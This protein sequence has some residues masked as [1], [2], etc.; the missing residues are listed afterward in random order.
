MVVK[1][2]SQMK[3]SMDNVVQLAA[4]RKRQPVC[5]MRLEK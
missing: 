2:T 1:E 4:Q 3:R 5:E